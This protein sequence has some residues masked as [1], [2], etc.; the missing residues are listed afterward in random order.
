MKCHTNLMRKKSEKE[1]HRRKE[2]YPESGSKKFNV[3]LCSSKWESERKRN[4]IF[5]LS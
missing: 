1:N 5:Y 2:L 4:G 3:I